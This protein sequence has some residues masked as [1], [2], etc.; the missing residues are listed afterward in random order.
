M[1]DA[2]NKKLDAI[3]GADTSRWSRDNR[4]SREI[5]LIHL[6]GLG[7]MCL[8]ESTFL[9]LSLH[10]HKNIVA[11]GYKR[12]LNLFNEYFAGVHSIESRNWLYLFS[13]IPS[14]TTWER[15]VFIGKDR[16]GRLRKR[17]QR[18]SKEP[19]IFIDMYP[20]QALSYQLSAMSHE[21][22]GVG[23][24]RGQG[25]KD[26]SGFKTL[27]PLNPRTLE[28]F[29]VEGY[30]LMQL[31]Q[32]NIQVIKKEIQPRL[33][34]RVIL[35]P[36]IGFKKAKWHHENFIK[37]YWLLKSKNVDV[38]ILE[39]LS[40]KLELKE[41]ISFQELADIR[42]FFKGGG[43]FVSNDSGMAHLAGI[44]GL[45]TI[46]LF[47]DYDPEIWHPRGHYKTLQ[48]RLDRIDIETVLAEIEGV[49]SSQ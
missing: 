15:I 25:V 21:P 48:Q 18:L 24:S 9:S 33:S 8:S 47:T 28:P 31:G 20:E 42:D 34:K 41:K 23:K 26:S 38:Y 3:I 11:V 13:K 10:F 29:H 40:I 4:K 7:D 6:G 30:Q 45:F 39:P 12:F 17:L 19:L 27:E 37:L 1:K 35:Y 22:R 5:L 49:L 2:V 16:A 43:I 46:T 32:Y 14:D 44:C 36:E